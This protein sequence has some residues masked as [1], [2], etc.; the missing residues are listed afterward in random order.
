VDIAE[1]SDISSSDWNWQGELS[2]QE[3]EPG[4]IKY[5]CVDLLYKPA[6]PN[7]EQTAENGMV[8]S[9]SDT[10]TIYFRIYENGKIGSSSDLEQ[11][12]NE[13]YQP[14]NSNLNTDLDEEGK[15]QKIRQLCMHINKNSSIYQKKAKKIGEN[16]TINAY[17]D[18]NLL[19]KMVETNSSNGQS[20]EYFYDLNGLIFIYSFNKTSKSESRYYF[21]NN[22]LYRWLKGAEKLLIQTES[23][24]FKEREKE[25]LSRSSKLIEN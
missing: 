14:I 16:I 8:L 12:K 4:I 13:K 19:K 21:H 7:E 18:G 24:E 6:E 22:Q 2:F 23:S 17:Y 1:V 9:K 10:T 25:L 5:Y 3:I 20:L 11:L 15:L